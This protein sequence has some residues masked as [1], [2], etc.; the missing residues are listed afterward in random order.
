M[1]VLAPVLD[2]KAA[3]SKPNL[4]NVLVAQISATA[5]LLFIA[6]INISFFF[7]CYA[8]HAFGVINWSLLTLW[9]VFTL[10]WVEKKPEI[11]P[12]YEAVSFFPHTSLAVSHSPTHT[13]KHTPAAPLLQG[14]QRVPGRKPNVS[15]QPSV[16]LKIILERVGRKWSE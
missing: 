8:N 14:V 3:L 1:H 10:T 9:S 12:F 13:Y 7:F 5:C 6:K 16:A 4:Q 11:Q 15:V 2:N